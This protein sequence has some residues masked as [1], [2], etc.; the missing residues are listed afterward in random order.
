V[1][2][3]RIP[4]HID[5]EYD[6]SGDG[7][8]L[9]LI[10][11]LGAQLISWDDAFCELLVRRGYMVIRYDNRDSGLSSILDER[12]V[13]DLLGML[14]GL[15]SPPYLLDDMA[16]DA[17]GLLDELCIDRA[18]VV[19]LSLGGMV[20]QILAMNHQDRVASI[21]AGLSGP[22]GR[23]TEIPASEVVEA[24]LQPPGGDFGERVLGAVALRRAL[25]GNGDG[26][27]P[28]EAH[29]RARAQISR[30]YNPAGTMR[31]AAAVLGT[32][33]LLADL[34]RI[35]VP[36]MVIHGELDPLVPYA[37]AKAAAEAIPG[38]VFNGIPNLGH[39]LPAAVA[40]EL[41]ERITQFHSR[42]AHSR[43]SPAKTT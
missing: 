15:G 24:L 23:P 2:R 17:V 8:P 38:A 29:R 19:G 6:V 20:A 41:V 35:D 27:D 31:Q 25:A 34:G 3:T 36:A 37:S 39:D 30:A 7:Q 10:G 21:V 14:V 11:G 42:A 5:L 13:P 18:H 22:A 28:E 4:G 1:P 33:N 12:G 9:L 40:L 43:Q 26:F 32:P 16:R